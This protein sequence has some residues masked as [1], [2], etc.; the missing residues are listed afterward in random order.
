MHPNFVL[1][2]AGSKKH[3]KYPG[4]V[5]DKGEFGQSS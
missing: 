4:I 5:A 2:V 1:I 3:L